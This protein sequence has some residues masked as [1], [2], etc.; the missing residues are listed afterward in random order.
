[1]KRLVPIIIVLLAIPCLGQNDSG[2]ILV[3]KFV[4]FPCDE[5]KARIDN[6]YN[7]INANPG[8]HGYFVINGSKEFLTEKL[9]VE[10]LFESAV[11][12]RRYD[13]TRTTIVRG[14]EAG[15]FEV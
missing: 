13:R 1:M 3:D 14:H 7:Q 2:G 15:R 11:E 6:I 12:T 8:S 9:D 5:F 10:L 4:Q